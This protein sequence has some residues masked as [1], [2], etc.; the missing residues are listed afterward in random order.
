[1]EQLGSGRNRRFQLYAGT[2]TLGGSNERL[3]SDGPRRSAIE[4][5]RFCF[6]LLCTNLTLNQLT[7][8]LP[9]RAAMG[10]APGLCRIPRLDPLV[11]HNAGATQVL[12]PDQDAPEVQEVR[13]DWPKWKQAVVCVVAEDGGICE[14]LKYDP[15]MG[16]MFVSLPKRG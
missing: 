6:Q 3:R 11:H 7:H 12:A 13:A 15:E 8:V 2:T 4:P 1:M 14:G 10:D 9:I 5:Q 16:L